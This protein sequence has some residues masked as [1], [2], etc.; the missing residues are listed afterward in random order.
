MPALNKQSKVDITL[1]AGQ[2]RKEAKL[3]LK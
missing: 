3:S 2:I 1:G